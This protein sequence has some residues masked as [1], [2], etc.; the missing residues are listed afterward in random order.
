MRIFTLM[1]SP[2][3]RVALMASGKVLEFA[4]ISPDSVPDQRPPLDLSRLDT[5]ELAKLRE[6]MGKARPPEV[7]Q[8]GVPAVI[9]ARV[10]RE[11]DQD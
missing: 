1:D 3:H 9:E 11:E 4:G 5:A 7:G 6:I 8:P 2:D 10:V